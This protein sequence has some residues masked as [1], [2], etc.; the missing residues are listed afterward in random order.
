[1]E[2]QT[3]PRP[4]RLRH[5]DSNATL[6]ERGPFHHTHLRDLMAAGKIPPTAELCSAVHLDWQPLT[7]HAVYPLI[8]EGR[9]HPLQLR[10]VAS[11][12]TPEPTPG[13][14]VEDLLWW[15]LSPQAQKES[16]N[17]SRQHAHPLRAEAALYL[18]RFVRVMAFFLIP[19]LWVNFML[20]IFSGLSSSLWQP[21]SYPALD[22]PTPLSDLASSW[23]FTAAQYLVP[24]LS[25]SYSHAIFFTPVCAAIVGIVALKSVPYSSHMWPLASLLL[26]ICTVILFSAVGYIYSSNNWGNPPLG[27]LSNSAFLGFHCCVLRWLRLT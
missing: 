4:F 9:S 11:I 3:L 13:L 24:L 20:G 18:S 16:M 14:S 22:F 2:T 7:D 8:R 15:S 1:M 5:L 19:Y 10:Q 25:F 26:A 21:W 17:A 12:P 23:G 6:I 27:L